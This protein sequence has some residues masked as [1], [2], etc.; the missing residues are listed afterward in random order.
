MKIRFFDDD[1]SVCQI[2]DLANV[3]IASEIFFLAKTPEELSLVCPT[4][5]VPDN[6]TRIESGWRCFRIEGTLDFQL[7]GILAAITRILASN[8]ISVFATSTYNTDYIL[9]KH[10]HLSAAKQLLSEAGYTIIPPS[11]Q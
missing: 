7:V 11:G 3:D 10:P 9:I 6:A 1:F 4:K 8:N 2:A 5:N